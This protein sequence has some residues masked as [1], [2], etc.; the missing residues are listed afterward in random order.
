[1]KYKRDPHTQVLGGYQSATTFLRRT[2]KACTTLLVRKA[3]DRRHQRNE[4][5]HRKV[6]AATG[7]TTIKADL[8]HP[9]QCKPT[10]VQGDSGLDLLL[11]FVRTLKTGLK[12]AL[13]QLLKHFIAK[14]FY[15]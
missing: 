11:N 4:K 13:L 10:V 14:P 8:S 9:E 5:N 12:V 6:P 2:G 15:Y 1:M 7:S 3:N